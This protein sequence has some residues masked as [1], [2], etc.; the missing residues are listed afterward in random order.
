MIVS[1]VSGESPWTTRPD[2]FFE[3]FK[4]SVLDGVTKGFPV[5]LPKTERPLNFVG[6][7]SSYKPKSL[8]LR[9]YAAVSIWENDG[10]CFCVLELPTSINQGNFPFYQ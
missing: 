2:P 7:P 5:I 8:R 3:F 9:L 4:G 6:C 10:C 1:A